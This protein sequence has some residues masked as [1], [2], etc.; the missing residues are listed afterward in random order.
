MVIKN[1]AIGDF[2]VSHSLVYFLWPAKTSTSI[3][4]QFTFLKYVKSFRQPILPTLVLS[5]EYTDN[6]PD[7]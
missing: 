6:R 4:L 5:H 3:D 2:I 7:C 1:T